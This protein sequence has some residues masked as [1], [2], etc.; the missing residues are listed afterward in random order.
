MISNCHSYIS[1]GKNKIKI[2]ARARGVGSLGQFILHL[3]FRNLVKPSSSPAGLHPV[4]YRA[5]VFPSLRVG[6]MQSG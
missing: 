4:T 1:G 3:C 6:V 5:R 2:M